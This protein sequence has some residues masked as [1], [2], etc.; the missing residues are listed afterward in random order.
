LYIYPPGVARLATPTEQVSPVVNVLLVGMFD[1]RNLGLRIMHSLLEQEDGVNVSTVFFKNLSSRNFVP[2]TQTEIGLF[3]KLVAGLKPD[4]VGISLMTPHF[5]ASK[6]LTAVVR[7]VAG[8]KVLWGGIHPTICPEEC[9]VHADMICRGEGEYPL[10]DVTRALRDGRPVQ[11]VAN[12]WIRCG[13]EVEKNPLRPLIQD[14]DA[15]PFPAY[16]RPD[17]YFIEANEVTRHDFVVENPRVVVASSRGCPNVC[18]YCVNSLLRPLYKGLGKH[19]RFRS[20]RSVVDEIHS[21][22]ALGSACASVHFSDEVF[23]TDAAWVEEF[24]ALYKDEVDVPFEVDYTTRHISED[25]YRKLRDAGMTHVRIGIQAPSDH[26][27]K[28]VFHRPGTNEELVRVANALHDSHVVLC[29]DFILNNPYD[30]PESL[31]D[32]IELMLRLP[33]PRKSLFHSLTYFPNYPLTKKAL[34]DGHIS[35]L[36][37]SPEYVQDKAFASFYYYPRLFP[38]SLKPILQNILWLCVMSPRDEAV[39][40]ALPAKGEKVRLTPRLLS[41]HL[42]SVLIGWKDKVSRRFSLW[43]G[44]FNAAMGHLRQGGVRALVRRVRERLAA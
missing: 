31:R 13:A 25:I 30:T 15:L 42:R 37:S 17:F 9:I 35:V 29:Y 16:K 39:R 40:R 6:D 4:L 44:T 32:G 10:L 21:V 38:L 7:E 2:P 36:E 14:L 43:K 19:V 5:P 33:L 11:N 41:L 22:K 8:A 26:V 27:R 12:L 34:A 23:A 1:Y 28:M 24:C 18:A 3:R 20:P